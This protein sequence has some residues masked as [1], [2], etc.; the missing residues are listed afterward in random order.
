MS[1]NFPDWLA[2]YQDY[3]SFTEAPRRMHFWAGVSAIAG[4]LRRRV[5]LDMGYFQWIPNFY[6]ILAAIPGI[7]AKSTTADIAM[8]LLKQVPGIRFGPHVV[9][10][11]ALI[12][13]FPEVAES[14]EW[15]GRHYTM[16]PL[17]C[18]ASE[19]GNLLDPEDKRLVDLLTTLWDN[20]ANLEKKTKGSGNDSLINPWLN[21]IGCTTP[22]WLSDNVP[23]S[24]VDGGL[25][26]RII[27]IYADKKERLIAYPGLKMPPNREQTVGRLVE[28]LTD[29][30]S[31]TGPFTMTPAAVAWGTHWYE[32]L[33]GAKRDD[34]VTFGNYIARKQ[35]HLHKLAMVLSAS[36]GDSRLIEA[37]DLQV[38]LAM[39]EDMEQDLPKVFAF[40][41]RTPMALN[42][43]RLIAFVDARRRTSFE[44]TYAALYPHFPD[45]DDFVRTLAGAIKAGHIRQE[46]VGPE[47]TIY[48][49]TT[50][51]EAP[52]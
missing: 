38:S 29:I 8:D 49:L 14:F 37:N 4:A 41:G 11:Q 32:A 22:S 12:T 17:T 40:L 33:W 26:S 50:R 48:L 51:K 19:L 46:I 35:T 39:L 20:R 7:V 47:K 1:R 18:V 2:A 10:W 43:S 42:A 3:A 9:T 45:Q 36:R 30:A 13:A 34:T 28:D 16:S 31:L 21:I 25:T 6:I 44:A 52:K 27:F 15:G 23:P 5:W 24:V